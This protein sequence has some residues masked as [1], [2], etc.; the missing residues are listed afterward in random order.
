[1][2]VSVIAEMGL[3]VACTDRFRQLETNRGLPVRGNGQAESQRMKEGFEASE[4][5]IAAL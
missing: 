3:R 5:W 2:M 4:F 1:M